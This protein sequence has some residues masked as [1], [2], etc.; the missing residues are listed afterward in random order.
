LCLIFHHCSV[1][2]L[3]W[4]WI[5]SL[6]NYEFDEYSSS[7]LTAQSHQSFYY[8]KSVKMFKNKNQQ[9]YVFVKLKD[10]NYRE[11]FRHMI[12]A[13]KK[14][15]LWRIVTNVKK[16]FT[17]NSKIIDSN[18]I[19]LKENVIFDYH[20]LNEKTVDKIDKMCINNVQMK[21]FSL[22]AKWNSRELW[23]H[24]KK[25]YSSTRWSFK[26]T[27]FNNLKI[28]TYESFIANLES[29]TLDVLIELKSQNLIIEQI[30]TLKVLNILKSSF[31]IVIATRTPYFYTRTPYFLYTY[32]LIF[33]HI[34]LC[35][36]N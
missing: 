26:W 27:A 15:E 32:T 5:S 35:L 21:F 36:S 11:W 8:L 34:H 33:I 20:F 22:K 30:V 4:C 12:F 7:S 1:F 23:N 28:L 24:L 31:F 18:A 17:L 13:L 19:E 14:I 9:L 3:V 29:K 6:I 25:R 2:I 16:I 10:I